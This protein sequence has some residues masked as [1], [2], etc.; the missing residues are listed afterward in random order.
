MIW[1]LVPEVGLESTPAREPENKG[2]QAFLSES[3]L[4]SVL[5]GTKTAPKVH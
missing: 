5:K 4:N 3:V 2:L 1:E